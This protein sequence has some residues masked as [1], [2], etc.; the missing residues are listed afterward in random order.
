MYRGCSK[1]KYRT[2][3]TYLMTRSQFSDLSAALADTVLTRIL[4]LALGLD[5]LV[6]VLA[7]DWF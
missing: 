4:G 2:V 7:V 5:A 1:E 6:C 3:R